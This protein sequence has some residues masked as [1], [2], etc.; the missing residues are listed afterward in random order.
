MPH[1]SEF[2]LA[3]MIALGAALRA[4]G[5]G[6]AHMEEAADRIVSRLYHAF[7]PDLGAPS[8]LALCRLYVTVRYSD[9]DD[10]LRAFAA[11][12]QDGEVPSPDA[13]CLTLLA[14]KGILPEWCSRHKSA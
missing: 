11:A 2:D 8:T 4:T 1:P 7:L 9:L 12:Q 13:R 5:S 14:T 10:V 6:A 3:E